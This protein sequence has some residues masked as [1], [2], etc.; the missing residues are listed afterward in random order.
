MAR[1]GRTALLAFV[2]L[3]ALATAAFAG[4][5][6]RPTPGGVWQVVAS[7]NVGNQANGLADVDALSATDA[8]AVGSYQFT[9]Q[10]SA[11]INQT[12]V[13]HWNGTAWSVVAS[14]DVGSGQNDLFAVEAV[15][16]NNVWAVGTFFDYNALAWLTLVEHWN[17]SAWSVVPSPSPSTRYNALQSIAA[18]GPNDVWAVGIEQ[19]SSPINNRTLIEHWNGTAWSVVP[20][21]NVGGGD[22]YLLGVAIASPADVWAVGLHD[23]QTL[24]EHWNGTAWSVV[25]SPNTGP[26]ANSLRAVT[27][28][29]ASDVWA[30]GYVYPGNGNPQRTLAEHWNGSAWSIVA[31]PNSGTGNNSLAAVAALSS[32]HVWAA[33]T[34]DSGSNKTLIERWDGASWKIVTSPSPATEAYLAGL[35]TVPSSTVWAVGAFEQGPGRTLVVRTTKG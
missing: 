9:P 2:T 23:V 5:A 26:D 32:T 22:N 30:V 25:A 19:T 10:G 18:A 6:N 15:S 12:L 24:T 16:A 34:F 27:V 8:W 1:L 29:S 11:P 28:V 4:Q 21:P 13:E 33:G 3:A 31:T 20:S 7:P 35:A 17:G 14:P